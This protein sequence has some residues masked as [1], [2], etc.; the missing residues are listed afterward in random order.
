[1][2][3]R[4]RRPEADA[5]HDACELAQVPLARGFCAPCRGDGSAAE[6]HFFDIFSQNDPER[7]AADMNG[8]REV[9][10]YFNVDRDDR[11][12]LESAGWM[13]RTNETRLTVIDV[14]REP[15]W[16]DKLAAGFDEEV[17]TRLVENRKIV[18]RDRVAD[19]CA[20]STH[21]E[22]KVLRGSPWVEIIREVLRHKH[23]LVVKAGEGDRGLLSS[24]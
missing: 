17:A 5:E 10:C 22:I 4:G 21:V 6:N 20:D 3:C 23:D 8:F 1:M 15:T 14:Q 19:L 9:L 18:L 13:A 2:S 11:A 7:T 16:H 24:P 12:A